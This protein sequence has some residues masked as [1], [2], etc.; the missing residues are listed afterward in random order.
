MVIYQSKTQKQRQGYRKEEF[1]WLAN[2]V[3][4]LL[5]LTFKRS[6]VKK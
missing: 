3:S 2:G 5:E 6:V 1:A 4:V